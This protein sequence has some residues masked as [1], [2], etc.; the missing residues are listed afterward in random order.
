MEKMLMVGIV[1]LGA[2]SLMSLISFNSFKKEMEENLSQNIHVKLNKLEK[3][4]PISL[5]DL[6]LAYGV[7]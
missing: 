5:V 2:L 3:N 6:R 1:A 7:P 4:T